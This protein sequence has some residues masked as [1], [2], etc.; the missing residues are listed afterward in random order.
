LIKIIAGSGLGNGVITMTNYQKKYKTILRIKHN[1]IDEVRKICED[2]KAIDTTFN[3]EIKNN[4]VIIYSENRK[5]AIA[6]KYWF[7]NKTDKIIYGV[8]KNG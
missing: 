3:Y 2:I 6:R 1:E 8:V 5:K 4:I 7:L